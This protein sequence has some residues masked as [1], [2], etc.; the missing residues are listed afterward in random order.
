MRISYQIS[1]TAQVFPN[2]GDLDGLTMREQ[3]SR[4]E[5]TPWISMDF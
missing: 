1:K 2:L 4:Y 3:K 5:A